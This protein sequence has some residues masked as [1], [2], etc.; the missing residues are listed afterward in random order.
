M[1]LP[2]LRAIDAG[3][4]S[5]WMRAP[6]RAS[7]GG[8]RLALADGLA[9]GLWGAVI[10]G[11][12]STA[13]EVLRGGRPLAATLA[14][15]TLVLPRE[16]RPL[17]LLAAAGP[18]HLALSSGWGVVLGLVLP[19]RAPAVWGAV[20]GA[21]IAALDLGVVGRRLPRI[22]ELETWPQVADHL[23]FGITVAVVV[24][25]RRSARGRSG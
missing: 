7:I 18:A 16:T 5:L 20:A 2:P 12:P 22:A 8:L 25:R 19:T 3:G 11:A 1:A 9:G 13:Y 6:G 23:A 14:A 17:P 4:L 10:G 15:G 24:A 21:G